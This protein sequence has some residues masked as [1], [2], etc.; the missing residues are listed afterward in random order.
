V[1]KL[2]FIIFTSVFFMA[3]STVNV[4]EPYVTFNENL[5][6]GT[7]ICGLEK[8][9]DDFVRQNNITYTAEGTFTD[10]ALLTMQ[11]SDVRKPFNIKGAVGGKYSLKG[12]KL[13][14]EIDNF[15]VT[16]VDDFTEKF[17]RLFK[18]QMAKTLE[19]NN[20][21]SV[22]TVIKLNSEQYKYKTSKGDITVCNRVK[23][24]N[25]YHDSLNYLI[26]GNLY[27]LAKSLPIQI[28]NDLVLNSVSGNSNEIIFS[29]IVD[30]F[31]EI[32]ESNKSSLQEMTVNMVCQDSQYFT[33]LHHGVR[34]MINY[35]DKKNDLIYSFNVNS[36]NCAAL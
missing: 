15:R 12:S 16:A 2:L 30:N 29:L 13:H 25:G 20:F 6:V 36:S 27:S 9:K 10:T 4:P 26:E 19:K 32:S 23:K 7:W 33:F 5:L 28:S 18:E 3:C 17:V 31:T 24:D 21:K 8:P 35:S 14:L 11:M 22:D 1:F 34:Y